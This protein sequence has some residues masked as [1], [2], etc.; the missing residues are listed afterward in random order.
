MSSAVKP[1]PAVDVIDER[2][3]QTDRELLGNMLTSQEAWNNLVALCDRYC[4]R[5]GGTE[6]EK[7]ARDYLLDR[8]AA[9]GVDNPRSEEF[10]YTGWTRGSA[11]LQLVSPVTQEL[12][13]ISLIYTG[14]C[15]VEGELVYVGHGTPADF[16]SVKDQIPGRIV[17]V[18]AWSPPY[19][20][21]RLHRG[22]K[23]ARA[24][25][26]GAKGFIWMRCAMVQS[27]L[28]ALKVHGVRAGP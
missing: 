25:A 5:F 16:E 22:E 13:C 20:W 28:L 27:Y 24:T 11:S 14:S 10:S 3:V 15:D 2:L 26:L 8:M 18:S 19:Y 7:G 17:M 4:S 21:R 12:P 1:K 6:E 23:L 9:Y